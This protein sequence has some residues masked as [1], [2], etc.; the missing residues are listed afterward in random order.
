MD[1]NK[2]KY[3]GW[4]KNSGPI[5]NRLWTKVPEILINVGDPSYFSTPFARLSMSRFV[6]QIFAIKSQSRRKTEEMEK[7]LAPIF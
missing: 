3:R 1:R 2:T 5:L 6:L 7:F 4:V